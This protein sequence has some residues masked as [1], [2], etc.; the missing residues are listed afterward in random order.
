M[1][2][3][4]KE[5][6]Q[7]ELEHIILEDFDSKLLNEKP[8]T[9][10]DLYLYYALYSDI[11]VQYLRLTVSNELRPLANEVRAVL[12]HLTEQNTDSHVDQ[13]ELEK[14]YGHMRRLTLDAFKILCD[15]Y[16]GFFVK[17]MMK[18]Y[19]YNFNSVNVGYLQKYSTLYIEANR[20]YT[21]AQQ[22][23][24]TGSDSTSKD[25][26]IRLYHIAAKKYIELKQLY[27]KNKKEINKVRLKTKILI[28]ATVGSFAFSTI[29]SVLTLILS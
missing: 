12:G 6:A 22:F 2:R 26:I 15:E 11:I 4:E 13:R 24:K 21:T 18:Q 20:A 17:T 5:Q 7:V 10:K 23:E 1:R 16:D 29:V 19:H 14:A 9:E 3:K 27:F 8:F 25:N 28:G